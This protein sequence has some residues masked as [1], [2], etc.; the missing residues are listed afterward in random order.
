VK[1]SDAVGEAFADPSPIVSGLRFLASSVERGSFEQWTCEWSAGPEGCCCDRCCCGGG[2]VGAGGAGGCCAG[3]YAD[4]GVSGAGDVGD[5]P[6]GES[7]D[8]AE[9]PYTMRT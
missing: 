6:V 3:V 9:L 1:A 4:D 5:E 8:S 7:D 2:G